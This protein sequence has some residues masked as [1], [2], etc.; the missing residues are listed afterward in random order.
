[1]AKKL[2]NRIDIGFISSKSLKLSRG[3]EWIYH[4]RYVKENMLHDCTNGIG[5]EKR[6]TYITLRTSSWKSWIE[7]LFSCFMNNDYYSGKLWEWIWDNIEM[8]LV[9]IN[10]RPLC[11]ISMSNLIV[12]GKKCMRQGVIR[13]DLLH[14]RE[15]CPSLHLF[16]KNKTP[17]SLK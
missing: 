14:L 4:N 2:V 11:L 16:F 9:C 10:N 17:K 15:I 5:G 1:M 7:H 3:Q 13:I 6:S 8:C 12:A